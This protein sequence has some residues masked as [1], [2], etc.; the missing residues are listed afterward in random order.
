MENYSADQIPLRKKDERTAQRGEDDQPEPRSSCLAKEEEKLMLTGA[1]R[2]RKEKEE[3][4]ALW[5]G[6]EAEFVEDEDAAEYEEKLPG[7]KLCYQLR[8]R[9][10]LSCLKRSNYIKTTGKRAVGETVLLGAVGSWCFI[11]SF[12]LHGGVNSLILGILSFLLIG[13]IWIVPQYAMR[14]RAKELAAAG[15]LL[16]FVYPDEVVVGEGKGEWHIP[17]DGTG[18]LEEFDHLMVLFAD[19]ERMLCIPLRAVEPAVLPDVEAM[20]LAGCRPKEQD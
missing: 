10:V 13:V 9:E 4:E 20:L 17:L 8:E 3:K 1:E 18:E 7:I 14:R 6:S 15:N 16:V 5:D 11:S 2:D 19:E 12:F